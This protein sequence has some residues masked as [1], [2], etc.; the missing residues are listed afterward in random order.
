MHHAILL[1]LLGFETFVQETINIHTSTIIMRSQQCRGKC[2][3]EDL[4]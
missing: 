2:L 4:R 1:E 3:F